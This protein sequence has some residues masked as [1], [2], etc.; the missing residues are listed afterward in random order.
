MTL[1]GLRLCVDQQS[2][3]LEGICE[4]DETTIRR[5]T[6]EGTGAILTTP[7]PDNTFINAFTSKYIAP[8][9]PRWVEFPA[10]DS[11]TANGVF[12]VVQP[13]VDPAGG[14]YPA[15]QYPKTVTMNTETVGSQIIYTTDGQIPK[16]NPLVGHVYPPSP[17]ITMGQVLKVKAFRSGLTP[18]SMVTA[19]F[20]HAQAGTPVFIPAPGAYPA[21]SYPMNVNIYSAPVF[22]GERIRYTTD[23]T[24]PTRTHGTAHDGASVVVSLPAN[25]WLKARVYDTTFTGGVPNYADSDQFGGA[26][27]VSPKCAKPTAN[28]HGGQYAYPKNVVLATATVGANIR[29]TI[30]NTNIAA[31]TVI[32]PNGN[33]T[34]VVHSG[35][36]VR[37]IAQ[38]ATFIDSDIMTETY[39]SATQKVAEPYSYPDGADITGTNIAVSLHCFTPNV[40]IVYTYGSQANPPPDPT[41]ATTPHHTEGDVVILGNIGHT[42][43]KM[44][45]FRA[46]MTDSV[47]HKAYFDHVSGG[48]NNR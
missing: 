25:R 48:S 13:V 1:T 14:A 30:N 18:S 2:D 42:M 17:S 28:P 37:A 20:T 4:R 33:H 45:A 19:P 35:D 47:I 26:Y 16:Q 9:R 32:P 22:T 38:K 21:D 46:D 23:T 5:I 11:A 10:Y 24:N 34:I 41:H 8:L 31:G 39:S 43:I 3:T 12:F 7:A 15:N 29:Y 6:A 44:L 27:T 36:V 40:T